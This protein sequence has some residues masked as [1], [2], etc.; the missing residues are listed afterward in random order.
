MKKI[1]NK[2]KN[3]IFG[4]P[5]NIFH[6]LSNKENIALISALAWV[7]MGAD[8][9]SSSAYGPESAYI[10]LHGNI[11]LA[12]ILSIAITV[13]I[14]IISLSYN[15]IIELFPEG[16]GGYKVASTLLSPKLGLVAG[17]ALIVDYIL[18]ISVSVASCVDSLISVLPLHIIVFIIK[19]KLLIEILLIIFLMIINIRGLKESIKLLLPLFVGFIITHFLII[20]F[21]II[22]KPKTYTEII[23]VHNTFNSIGLGHTSIWITIAI[24]LR[25]YSL[26][27]GTYTGIEAVSNNIGILAEPRIRTGKITMLYM[28]ISLSFTASGII[29]LYLF[30]EAKPEFGQT[31]NAVVYGKI[32]SHFGL[33]HWW[34]NIIL[35]FESAL[36]LI[37]A[38]TGIL[39]CP[40]VMSNMA[41]DNWLPKRFSQ[42]SDRLVTQNGIIIAGICAI[43]SLVLT[44][45]S[46]TILIILY[47]IN[48]FITFSLS[49]LGLC[50]HWVK[51]RKKIKNYQLKLIFSIIAF[52]ICFIILVINI[53]E[54]FN[55]GGWVVILIPAL[56]MIISI[57]IHK[58]YTYV[59]NKLNKLDI[60]AAKIYKLNNIDNT[61]L[62][63][64]LDMNAKTAIFFVN[65]HIGAGIQC[66]NHVLEIFPNTFKN[67]VFITTGEVDSK[68]LYNKN[69]NNTFY[70]NNLELIIDYLRFFCSLKEIPSDGFFNYGIDKIEELTTLANKSLEIYPN[71]IFFGTTLLFNE[72]KFWTKLLHNNT[73]YTLQKNLHNKNKNMILLPIQI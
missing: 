73:A 17:V 4:N 67:F 68:T 33:N 26:G 47:S 51:S 57:M 53:F 40:A 30:W 2:F 63:P 19:Y 31:L 32:I 38:N 9:L 69:F 11:H 18:T 45:G 8:G 66:I 7:G 20:V 55:E 6:Q 64:T 41:M 22:Y 10:A 39:G 1:L 27:G 15:Q 44:K 62:I 23:S 36:L 37:G 72:D 3:L 24:L 50:V 29:L 16:G 60:K 61:E 35:F 59:Q 56:L 65:S 14:F 54:K 28:A 71:S 34:V 58:H 49:F 43:L 70:F 48:V 42:L 52:V 13:T 12:I 46:L 25:A 5:L 21:G